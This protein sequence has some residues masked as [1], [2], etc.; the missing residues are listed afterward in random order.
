MLS[1][2]P[3]AGTTRSQGS[4]VAR[5]TSVRSSD[6]AMKSDRPMRVVPELSPSPYRTEPCGSASTS[7]VFMPRRARAAA[8]LIAVV[9]LPTP[10]FWLTIER[11]RG[12]LLLGVLGY[13]LAAQGLERL[14]GMTNPAFGF[15]ACGWLGEKRLE[16]L[17]RAGAIA[18]FQQQERQSVVRSGQMW[19]DLEGVAIAPHRLLGPVRLREGDR[20]VLEDLRV[21]RT[22]AQRESVRRQCGVKIPLSLQRHRLAQIIQALGLYIGTGLPADQ[23]TPPGHAARGCAGR[24]NKACGRLARG[25]TRLGQSYHVNSITATAWSR[26]QPPCSGAN[27]TLP[28]HSTV[29]YIGGMSPRRTTVEHSKGVFE[30]E[31]PLFGELSRGLALKVARDYDPEVVVGIA[32]AGV[33]PGAVIAAIL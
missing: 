27:G 20:H 26:W 11:T 10:P 22:I 3:P 31:W 7:S 19:R 21:V 16:V 1:L 25:T 32:T 23:A 14:F 30:V 4:G 28:G 2:T 17:F 5:T 9:V 12:T 18:S 15:G 33:V 6:P 24:Q 29:R 8:R 13:D